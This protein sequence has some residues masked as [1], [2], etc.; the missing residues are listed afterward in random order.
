MVNL[1]KWFLN[2][3]ILTFS[4]AV[5]SYFLPFIYIS[6]DTIWDK[7]KL[8]FLAGLLLG[9][10]NL[11]VKPIVKILSL[12]INILTLGI[13]NIIINAGM[14]WIVDSIIKGLEIEG[15]WGYVWS[16]IVISIISIVVSKI[17]FFREKKD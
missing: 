10:L 3:L 9:L 14:L 13:F 7:F 16:S 15:F 12:P 4:I 1:L 5:A 17:I 11:L 8:S 6:G 2:W